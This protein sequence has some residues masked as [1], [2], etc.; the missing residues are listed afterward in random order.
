[1]VYHS[2]LHIVPCENY[3]LNV[4]EDKLMEFF[5]GRKTAKHLASIYGFS[6]SH[7]KMHLV[8]LFFFIYSHEGKNTTKRHPQ[9]LMNIL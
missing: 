9:V 1:M 8:I 2:L 5:Y 4:S 3:E 6:E 7:W